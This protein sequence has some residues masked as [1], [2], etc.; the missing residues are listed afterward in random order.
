MGQH[1]NW[2]VLPEKKLVEEYARNPQAVRHL[3]S[4]YGVALRTIVSHLR[5]SGVTI[6][7]RSEA[8]KGL[9]AGEDH[10][11]WRGGRTTLGDGYPGVLDPTHG[12]ARRSGYVPE[13]VR[14]AEL[15]L[16]KPL[17]RKHPVHHVDEDRT[18]N[19]NSNLVICEDEG[20]HRL[21]HARAR[22][23]KAG[24]DPNLDK[25]CGVC[26]R[27]KPKSEFYRSTKH[28]YGLT[29]A[30]GTCLCRHARASRAALHHGMST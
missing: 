15:A 11:N 20:Y 14:L 12:R 19:E 29:F 9:N 3:A 4:K 8:N 30:C 25:I 7:S 21:L 22:V 5:R 16:G 27:I 1:F 2:S 10:H 23:L 24:G 6:R 28:S 18:H 26:K 13:H 17:R